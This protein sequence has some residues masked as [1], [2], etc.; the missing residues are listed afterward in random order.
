MRGQKR[1][2]VEDDD[3]G[4]QAFESSLAAKDESLAKGFDDIEQ[5]WAPNKDVRGLVQSPDD[6]VTRINSLIDPATAADMFNRYCRDLAPHLPAVV[7][8]P[9]TTAEQVFRDRPILYH[10]ARE[11]VGAIADCVV[12]NG[13]KSLEL[14]QAMQVLALYYKPPEEN[15]QTNFYQIIHMAA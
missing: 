7:F 1:R 4:R 8:P 15:E 2:R 14:I 6:F 3:D 11:A 12:R 13:A 10:L 9:D 5:A